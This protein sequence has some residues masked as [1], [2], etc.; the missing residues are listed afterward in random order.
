ML[1]SPWSSLL[2]GRGLLGLL[3]GPV[4]FANAL[5]ASS[6]LRTEP[7]AER[8]EL[9]LPGR[10]ESVR[11]RQAKKKELESLWLACSAP[12]AS[13]ELLRPLPMAVASR[14]LIGY[15]LG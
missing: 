11:E 13:R 2:G 14:F 9:G 6:R 8:F 4:V 15:D 12:A 10:L 3:I 5:S 1:E 7:R